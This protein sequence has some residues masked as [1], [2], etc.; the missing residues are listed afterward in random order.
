VCPG[1]NESA[2]VNKSGHTRQGTPTS[3]V[4]HLGNSA[5][6]RW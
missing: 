3:N 5:D 2:G 6:A 4:E 1:V